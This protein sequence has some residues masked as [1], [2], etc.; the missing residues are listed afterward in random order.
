MVLPSHSINQNSNIL[1]DPLSTWSFVLSWYFCPVLLES[2]INVFHFI[3]CETLGFCHSTTVCGFT[4]TSESIHLLK[5]CFSA[6]QKERSRSVNLGFVSFA[7]KVESCCRSARFSS[8]KLPLD[9]KRI[10]MAIKNT[11]KSL[12]I[13]WYIYWALHDKFYSWSGKCIGFL[14]DHQLEIMLNNYLKLWTWWD[15]EE[16][17]AIKI[18]IQFSNL[19]STDEI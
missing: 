15:Y 12:I 9:L 18:P 17:Q 7:R 6:I 4:M 8:K 19:K 14:W 16:R 11:A 3:P 2:F 1:L 10:R 5:T 13:I